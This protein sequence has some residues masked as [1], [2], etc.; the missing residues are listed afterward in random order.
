M[1][2]MAFPRP[3]WLALLAFS[4]CSATATS[5]PSD[6]EAP[7]AAAIVDLAGSLA[8][9]PAT[10][11]ALPE[12]GAD[13]LAQLD[14]AD[15]V[16]AFPDTPDA[17]PDAPDG[18]PDLFESDATVPCVPA[19]D[20]TPSP[21]AACGTAEPASFGT[22]AVGG[23]TL[24]LDGFELSFA[25]YG[26]ALRLRYEPDGA[27]IW[28]SGAVVSAPT[29][30][31]VGGTCE[32]VVV[33]SDGLVAEVDPAGHVRVRD[34]SGSLLLDEPETAF[35]A[36]L[37]Q[38]RR[39]F[40]PNDRVF[41]LGPKTG[42]LN[43]RG[44][45][46]TL[47][48]TDAYDSQYGGFAPDGDPLYQSIPFVLVRRSTGTHGVFE[49]APRRQTWDLTGAS[50]WSVTAAGVLDEYVIPGPTPAAVLDRYTALTGRPAMPPRWAL[51]F[52]QSRWGWPDEETFRTIAARFR[53]E[54]I[55]CD[56][57]WF[58][59]QAMDGFRSFTWGDA[60]P[61]PAP[62]NADLAALGFHTVAIVDP[63]IKVDPGWDIYD[64]G[65]LGGHLLGAPYVGSVWPGASVF[66]DFTRPETRAWWASLAAR[67]TDVGID[68]LWNDMNEPSDFTA[69]QGGTVPDG[70]PVDGD[71]QGGTM[72]TGHQV[73][74]LREAEATRTG[75]LA[76]LP[77]RRPFVLTRAGYAGI[78]RSAMAWTGDAPSREDVLDGTLPMLLGMGLS[79]TPFVGSD[80]G[81]YSGTSSP[82]LFARWMALGSVSPFFRA[83]AEKS[84]PPMLPWDF[85]TEVRDASRAIIEARYRL[86]PY[87]Y[88]LSDE[89]RRTGAPLLRPLFWHFDGV[90]DVEDEAMVGPFLLVAPILAPV[91]DGVS[92][93]VKGSR[94]VVLPA[95][96]WFDVVS[97][98]VKDGPA[99]FSVS[100]PLAALPMWAREG[101]IV[102][103][104]PV[105]QFEGDVAGALEVT[106]YPSATPT[107][108]T[109]CEDLGDGPEGS[110][111]RRTV[112]SQ[113][114]LP[115]GAL[116][117]ASV[118]GDST[119]EPAPRQFVI[120][121]RRVDHRPTLVTLDGVS[122]QELSAALDPAGEVVSTEP[123]WAWDAADLA[124]VVWFPDPGVFTLE[125]SYDRT[126]TEL[127]PPV[128]VPLRVTV[129]PGSS[130]VVHV[131]HSANAWTHVPLPWKDGVATGTAVVPR[132][133]WFDY[134][135]TRGDWSTVEKWPGCQEA[136]NRYAFGA[137]HPG[138]VDTVFVWADGCP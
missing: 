78:Q 82:A 26:D 66:P 70:L 98:A 100:G 28:D 86:L 88:S 118:T 61:G 116:V 62:L 74:A 48:N 31:G 47:W 105:R 96:R 17:H 94:T 59:I 36:A 27:V 29:A 92:D 7:D 129:P 9:L 23:F 120:R 112:W 127:A 117:S 24:D 95:G 35:N 39:T 21:A 72:A 54:K 41:G 77:G 134:K 49:D 22:L 109:L 43:R 6:G 65:L 79:G 83:H 113:E 34:A 2:P 1:A 52:H 89:A 73:Y 3:S 58:D 5:G 104:G 81:G 25:A 103:R 37:G 67:H 56:S 57:L 14:A 15:I 55:P 69:N 53:T 135:Y 102:P 33:C 106:V 71:G 11:D 60:F 30:L 75:L 45:L 63:G 10:V 12:D 64:Q 130:G 122:L 38:L 87:W 136:T 131:A 119:F 90:D 114:G 42:P 76:A 85:G 93:P 32:G 46:Y 50:T 107:T 13:D 99:T 8:E 111:W 133:Q 16:P 108:F 137:A 124:L 121:L 125:A 138:K 40:E 91:S 110:P 126:L 115:T 128:A 19:A 101:A 97:G 44:R 68:G 18:S 51:G 80:V 123:G 84:A 4:A 20:A 132:G